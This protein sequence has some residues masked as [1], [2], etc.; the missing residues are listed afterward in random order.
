MSL[1]EDAEPDGDTGDVE[2][3]TQGLPSRSSI[4]LQPSSPPAVMELDKRGAFYYFFDVILTLPHAY[5]FIK[6][7]HWY[8]LL[9]LCSFVY[10]QHKCIFFLDFGMDGQCVMI[11][12]IVVFHLP[13][14]PHCI[15]VF[16]CFVAFHLVVRSRG[17]PE[18]RS[19]VSWS[20]TTE[21]HAALPIKALSFLLTDSLKLTDKQV[22]TEI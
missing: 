12:F 9:H 10:V 22:K 16:L 7:I 11:C 8:Q 5:E 19:S 4:Q 18:L 21:T 14:F 1:R 2:G 20:S 17:Q 6:T 15:C 13:H 3:A